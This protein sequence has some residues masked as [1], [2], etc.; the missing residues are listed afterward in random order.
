MR[1]WLLIHIHLTSIDIF[2]C[3]S[4][5]SEKVCSITAIVLFPANRSE[6]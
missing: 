1:H 3:A 6:N 2:S 5:V 4:L